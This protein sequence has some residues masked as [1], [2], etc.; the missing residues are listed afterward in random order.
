MPMVEINMVEINI[1]VLR[2]VLSMKEEK[3]RQIIN[4]TTKVVLNWNPAIDVEPKNEN[5][6]VNVPTSLGDDPLVIV[7]INKAG[8]TLAVLGYD[9]KAE[10]FAQQVQE[11]DE[12][13]VDVVAA[14]KKKKATK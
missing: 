12:E 10:E 1:E 4:Q 11:E 7:L 14:V 9:Q 8:K 13:S 2:Y 3:A 6:T 5:I